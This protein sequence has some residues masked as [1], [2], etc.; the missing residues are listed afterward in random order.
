MASSDSTS[1]NYGTVLSDHFQGSMLDRPAGTAGPARHSCLGGSWN[2][3]S[4][5][6]RATKAVSIAASCAIWR[7]AS[8]AEG[9]GVLVVVFW[10]VLLVDYVTRLDYVSTC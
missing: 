6:C 10:I 2:E 8:P 3:L 5:S 9:G 7:A 4:G 1:T